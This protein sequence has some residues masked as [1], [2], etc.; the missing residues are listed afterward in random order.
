MPAITTHKQYVQLEGLDPHNFYRFTV[1]ALWANG[2]PRDPYMDVDYTT[3]QKDDTLPTE[4]TAKVLSSSSIR[5]NW[6]PATRS[7]RQRPRYTIECN[8]QPNQRYTT[9]ETTYDMINLAD[10]EKNPSDVVAEACSS[11]CIR[12]TWKAPKQSE[13][14]DKFY[15]VITNSDYNNAQQT[16]KTTI[17][18]EYLSPGTM[19]VFTVRSKSAWGFLYEPGGHAS[20]RTREGA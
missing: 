20:A 18:I 5:L 8:L 11:T 10:V 15:T 9:D 17:D 16:E 14:L 6:K 3:P 13:G 4:L 19:Y 7:D 1:Y 2:T 12:L